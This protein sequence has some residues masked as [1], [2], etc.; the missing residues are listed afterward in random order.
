MTS[1][2]MPTLTLKTKSKQQQWTLES[3]T[4][5]VELAER[6]T[7]PL[8]FGC[9]EADCGVCAVRVVDNPEGI[10]P[11]TQVEADFLK[12][13]HADPEERLGCQ[14]RIIGDVTLFVDE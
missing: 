14:C 11:A 12:A 10:S 7:T 9:R 13:L 4:S 8:V 6:E 5:L 2:R 1:S 3:G